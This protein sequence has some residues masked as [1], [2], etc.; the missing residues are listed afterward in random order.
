[1][2]KDFVVSNTGALSTKQGWRKKGSEM[3]FDAK[4]FIMGL[5]TGL[6]FGLGIADLVDKD[7]SQFMSGMGS[8]LAGLGTVLAAIVAY[9]AYKKWYKQHDYVM[10]QNWS[11]EVDEI[12]R[13]LTSLI[14]NMIATYAREGVNT[15][16]SINV[17]LAITNAIV[18]L[19]RIE[20]KYFKISQHLPDTHTYQSLITKDLEFTKEKFKEFVETISTPTEDTGERVF[21]DT[22]EKTV[23]L[24]D[25]VEILAEMI[26]EDTTF[27]FKI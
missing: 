7:L 8:I 18:L 25:R 9:R 4:T 11:S 22:M 3:E 19:D 20:K 24:L 5:L 23:P 10:V 12:S 1:M 13:E 17:K 2:Y 15:H 26:S 6:T 14:V 16:N 27:L 21:L